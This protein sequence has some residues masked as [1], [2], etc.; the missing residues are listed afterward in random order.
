MSDCCLTLQRLLT[1]VVLT[2]LLPLQSRAE[3]VDFKRNIAPILEERC[4]Y[5][6]GEDEQESNLRLDLRPR[7]LRGGDSGL[8]AVEPGKPESSYLIELIN[9]ADAEMRMPPDEDKLPAEE[10]ALL[11]RWKRWLKKSQTTGRSSR[12]FVPTFRRLLA[13]QTILWMRFCSRH[14]RKTD[15][16]F[17]NVQMLD[18]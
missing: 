14:L 13:A 5:C 12:S 3:D 4:W 15:C 11:T 6:H 2:V 17:L 8:S 1:T 10:I 16:P 7:M 18:R 9:H